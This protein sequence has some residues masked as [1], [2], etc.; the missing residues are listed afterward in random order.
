MSSHKRTTTFTPH[1]HSI[2]EIALRE[3]AKLPPNPQSN[4]FVDIINR[5]VAITRQNEDFY[6]HPS[7]TIHFS[8]HSKSTQ[9]IINTGLRRKSVQTY[10][11]RIN[12]RK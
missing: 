11:E 3:V 5:K 2:Y 10:R 12:T 6:S 1:F 4:E 8:H 9:K 7:Q